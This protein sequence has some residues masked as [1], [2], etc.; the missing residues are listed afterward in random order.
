MVFLTLLFVYLIYKVI[1][2]F[3]Y[4]FLKKYVPNESCNFLLRTY[5]NLSHWMVCLWFD[6]FCSQKTL[7]LLL[8]VSKSL[9]LTVLKGLFGSMSATK[10]QNSQFFSAY[11]VCILRLTGYPPVFRGW[12][13]KKLLNNHEKAAKRKELLEHYFWLR[14]HPT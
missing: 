4:L 14:S 10:F 11:L 7:S 8:I 5:E 1:F 3:L 2:Y 13:Y 9:S 6:P 12:N